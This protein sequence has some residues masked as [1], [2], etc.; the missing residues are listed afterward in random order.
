MYGWRD[1]IL[2]RFLPPT[3]AFFIGINL[4]PE[5][6]LNR[7]AGAAPLEAESD[8]PGFLLGG[9]KKKTKIL[10]RYYL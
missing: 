5:I 4:F 1:F 10:R 9:L 8:S 3:A 6:P 7:E 2:R